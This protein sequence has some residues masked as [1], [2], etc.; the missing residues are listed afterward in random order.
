M[1]ECSYKNVNVIR[2]ELDFLC[3]DLDEENGCSNALYVWEHVASLYY[4]IDW[5]I[6][7]NLGMNEE[8]IIQ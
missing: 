7:T 6:F 4:K 5:Y 3:I 1:G 2:A 8:R